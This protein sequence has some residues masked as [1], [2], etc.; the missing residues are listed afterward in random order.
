[1]KVLRLSDTSFT[2]VNDAGQQIGSVSMSNGMWVS[3]FNHGTS[4]NTFAHAV[5]AACIAIEAMDEQPI[6]IYTIPTDGR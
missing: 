3:S 4:F 2:I 1:M 6:P 5:E